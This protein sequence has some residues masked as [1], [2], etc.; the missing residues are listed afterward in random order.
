MDRMI[1]AM[2]RRVTLSR[3][4]HMDPMAV[5][6]SSSL[7]IMV[8]VP[9]ETDIDEAALV[10]D[11]A[12]DRVSLNSNVKSLGNLISGSEN[13][14]IIRDRS[15]VKDTERGTWMTIILSTS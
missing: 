14:C 2:Q 6:R 13:F 3:R 10:L 5:R 8:A 9:L 1:Y 7:S 11:E 15:S 12:E 4:T